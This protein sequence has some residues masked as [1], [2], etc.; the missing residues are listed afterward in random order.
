MCD[1]TRSLEYNLERLSASLLTLT[2]ALIEFHVYRIRAIAF[3]SHN[4][5]DEISFECYLVF[6]Y[7]FYATFE[8][9]FSE[10]HQFSQHVYLLWKAEMQHFG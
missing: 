4:I 10:I 6:L 2:A 7:F 9:Y 3:N 5:N 1:E 8:L